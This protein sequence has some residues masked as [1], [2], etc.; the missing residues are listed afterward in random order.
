[1]A[2]E[3]TVTEKEP[4]DTVLS[5][6]ESI[7]EHGFAVIP[8]VLTPEE[9]AQLLKDLAGSTP[10]RTKAGVRHIL[11][12]ASV[13]KLAQEARLIEIAR[14][15]LGSDAF[16]FR[17]TLFDKSPD[18][19]WLVVWH[20]D[21]ALPLRERREAPGWGPW[22][23][24]QGVVYAGSWPYVFTLMIRRNRMAPCA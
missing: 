2:S 13:A 8:E 22:S 23:T 1:L 3:L 12:H 21:T 15:V 14:A 10:R 4:D 6:V 20:Q 11:G 17:A 7:E 18:A 9:V 16:P 5:W 19:N 24:K